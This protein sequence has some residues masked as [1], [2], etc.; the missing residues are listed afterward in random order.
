MAADQA[1][2]LVV[3]FYLYL[4]I[5]YVVIYL[6][7]TRGAAMKCISIR[8]PWAWLIIAGQKDIEN[9]NWRT[10]FRGRILVH[11]AKGMTYAEY[12]DA[13]GYAHMIGLT[14]GIRCPNYA[15]LLRG[16]IIGA[17]EIV[18]CVASSPSPW[19]SGRFGFVMRNPQPMPFF[20]CKGALGIFEAPTSIPLNQN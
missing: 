2:P 18:D 8:Q 15:D 19:F 10:N 1:R 12:F 3:G 14:G 17:V 4:T 20:P 5:G 13:I 11:A 9:R 7:E 16:G 6:E